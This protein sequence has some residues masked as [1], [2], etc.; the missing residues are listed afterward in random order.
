MITGFEKRKLVMFFHLSNMKEVFR[1]KIRSEKLHEMKYSPCGKYLAVGSNENEV[2]IVA[3]DSFKILGTCKGS[4]V[5]FL[6]KIFE[7]ASIQSQ[8]LYLI[9]SFELN[10]T[11]GLVCR[12][13]LHTNQQP[14]SKRWRSVPQSTECACFAFFY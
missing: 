10:H 12:Q 5:V 13:S 11:F 1:K 9:R 14:S 7:Q 6:V 8:N 3:S 2:D 4:S